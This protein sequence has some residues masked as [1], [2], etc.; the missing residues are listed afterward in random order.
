MRHSKPSVSAVARAGPRANPNWIKRGSLN[1]RFTSNLIAFPKKLDRPARS[2]GG[3]QL[4]VAARAHTSRQRLQ[5]EASP[6]P[7]PRLPSRSARTS[8]TPTPCR[9]ARL[10]RA[11]VLLLSFPLSLALPTLYH[12]TTALLLAP[13]FSPLCVVFVLSFATTLASVPP[14]LGV[15]GVLHSARALAVGCALYAVPSRCCVSL[16]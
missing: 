14:V 5:P 15:F 13:T 9:Y 8:T 11:A 2:G 16:F 1:G 3:G 6:P 10:S 4:L 7:T 12:Y